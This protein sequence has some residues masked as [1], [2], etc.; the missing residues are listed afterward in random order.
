M[1]NGALRRATIYLP[2]IV[3][4]G[5]ASLCPPY[6]SASNADKHDTDSDAFAGLADNRCFWE[7]PVAGL[8]AW[9]RHSR[10]VRNISP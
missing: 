5:H 8:A 3:D 1:G 7:Q 6:G 4:G 2:I 9:L 10:L